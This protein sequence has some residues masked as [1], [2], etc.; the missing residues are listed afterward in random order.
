M[1]AEGPKIVTVGVFNG[2]GQL[3]TGKRRD[4]GLW[5]SPGGH[6]DAGETP[7][8]AAR[9]EVL[10]ETGLQVRELRFIGGEEFTSHRTGKRFVVLAFMAR[11]VGDF[12]F[13]HLDPDH[14]VSE[15]RWVKVHPYSAELQ[16]QARHAKDDLVLKHLGLG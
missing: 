8:D 10:E 12:A 1:E 5:T 7:Y 4:N 16:R 13:S 6:M 9:R 2:S 11:S 3:L 14:E 15:W